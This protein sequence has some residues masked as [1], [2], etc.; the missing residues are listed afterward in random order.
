[1]LPS[2]FLLAAPLL[3]LPPSLWPECEAEFEVRDLNR[4]LLHGGLP[5][6]LLANESCVL[7]SLNLVAFAA[8]DRIVVERY[9]GKLPRNLATSL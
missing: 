5:E 7:G 1:M 4:R 8:D 3:H 9:T 2:A 6:P